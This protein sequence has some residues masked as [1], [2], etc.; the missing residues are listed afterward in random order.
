MENK[1]YLPFRIIHYVLMI[2]TFVLGI[3]NFIKNSPADPFLTKLSYLLLVA[4]LV[5][6]FIYAILD[7]RKKMQNIIKALCGHILFLQLFI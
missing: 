5:L 7:Y 3:Y 1:K 4:A 6:G 2:A